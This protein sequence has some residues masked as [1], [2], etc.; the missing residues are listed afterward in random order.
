LTIVTLRGKNR[1]A[2][3]SRQFTLEEE[4]HMKHKLLCAALT[5]GVIGTAAGC[6]KTSSADQSPSPSMNVP[7]GENARWTGRI[8]SVTQSRGD[9]AQSTRDRSYGD[10]TWSHGM[11]PSLSN[12]NLTFNYAGQERFLSWA[13]VSGNCGQPSLPI[14]PMSN[15]PELNIGSGGR[16]QVTSSIPTELPSTGSYHVDIYR[17]R[18]Q[19]VDALIACGNLKYI[20]G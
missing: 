4:S 8:Q 5:V 18:Q 10:F 13:I 11:S 9:V 14:L 17:S 19:S 6:A 3:R 20:N 1:E 15:F 2:A 16:V 12:V 7:A